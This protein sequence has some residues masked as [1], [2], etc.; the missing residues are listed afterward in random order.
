MNTVYP[1]I[2][3]RKSIP[4]SPRLREMNRR[5]SYRALEGVKVV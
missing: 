5:D 1:V 3:R 2:A 4:T